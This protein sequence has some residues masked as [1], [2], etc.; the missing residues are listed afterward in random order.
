MP[1]D[2]P[3][4]SSLQRAA[5]PA[6]PSPLPS[7]PPLGGS[8]KEIGQELTPPTYDAEWAREALRADTTGACRACGFV[9]TPSRRQDGRLIANSAEVWVSDGASGPRARIAGPLLCRSPHGCPVCSLRARDAASRELKA[10]VA[11]W[12]RDVRS[13]HLLTLTIRHR[14]EHGLALQLQLLRHAWHHLTRGAG[15]RRATKGLGLGG[16]AHVFEVRQGAHGWH[17]HVHALLLTNATGDAPLAERAIGSARRD[18]HLQWM[19]ALE[20]ALGELGVPEGDRDEFR[21]A[22]RRAVYLTVAGTGDYLVKP[23]D[24]ATALASGQS[25]SASGTRSVHEIMWSAAGGSRRDR[26]LWR[27]YTEALRGHKLVPGLGRLR[28]LLQVEARANAAELPTERLVARIPAPT[29]N[30]ISRRPGVV[31]E[32]RALATQHGVLG[33]AMVVARECWNV[34]TWFVTRPPTAVVRLAQ[35]YAPAWDPSLERLERPRGDRSG[36]WSHRRRRIAL[37]VHAAR[38]RTGERSTRM[39]AA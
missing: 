20:R 10:V 8:T 21:P 9:A 18:I 2:S 25:E 12:R 38:R 16:H 6:S 36:R 32:I 34:R 15:W 27:E 33:V 17:A 22:T 39:A 31:S 13:V 26:R 28:Q 37:G 5:A 29:F 3:I 11:S 24:A 14:R 7:F 30:G 23:A 4:P 35:A 19:A 1:S